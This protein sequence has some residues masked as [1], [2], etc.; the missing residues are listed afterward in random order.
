MLA[1]ANPMTPHTSLAGILFAFDQHLEPES[2]VEEG[3][4]EGR[5]RR[6]WRRT[7]K[8]SNGLTTRRYVAPSRCKNFCCWQSQWTAESKYRVAQKSEKGGMDA[9]V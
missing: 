9:R 3:E 6:G 4:D 2:G 5:A 8:G 1:V 7:T